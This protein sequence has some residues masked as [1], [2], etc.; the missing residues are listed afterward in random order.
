MYMLKY[1]LKRIGLML[2]T[3]TIIFVMCFFLIKLLPVDLTSVGIGQDRDIIIAQ[4]KDRGYYKP[5]PEQLFL[6]IKRIIF[7]RVLVENIKIFL[8]EKIATLLLLVVAV[9]PIYLFH[10]TQL[11]IFLQIHRLVAI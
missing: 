11:T 7:F 4:L 10:Q 9:L 1:I 8:L 6:Y 2:M 3:F 5:I